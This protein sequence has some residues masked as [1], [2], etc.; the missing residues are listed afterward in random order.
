MNLGYN[1]EVDF[2]SIGIRGQEIYVL[3]DENQRM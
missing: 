1:L 2:K 3:N